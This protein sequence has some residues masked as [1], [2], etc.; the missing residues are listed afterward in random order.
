VGDR[1]VV[2]RTDYAD[3]R[4]DRRFANFIEGQ[5]RT[6]S[7]AMFTGKLA[8]EPSRSLGITAIRRMGER[9]PGRATSARSAGSGHDAAQ[10]PAGPAGE[11]A[12]PEHGEASWPGRA[13]RDECWGHNALCCGRQQGRCRVSGDAGAVW[14]PRCIDEMRVGVRVNRS[15]APEPLN[16]GVHVRCLLC[17]MDYIV[18]S[19]G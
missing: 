16:M 18:Q 7:A 19:V 15:A 3:G 5:S 4:A 11:G 13:A 10:D 14:F 12:P 2:T 17:N 6:R 9:D 8:R 1:Q